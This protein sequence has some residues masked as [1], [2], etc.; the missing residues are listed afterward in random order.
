MMRCAP[1]ASNGPSHLGLCTLHRESSIQRLSRDWR[2]EGRPTQRQLAA[3]APEAVGREDGGGS[4]L[5]EQEREQNTWSTGTRGGEGLQ[6]LRRGLLRVRPRAPRTHTH[7]HAHTRACERHE[8]KCEAGGNCPLSMKGVACLALINDVSKHIFP[9]RTVLCSAHRPP[10]PPP[11][12]PPCRHGW[13][14]ASLWRGLGDSFPLRPPPAPRD[15][16]P[17]ARLSAQYATT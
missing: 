12:P 6:G 7:T 9:R 8:C 4:S 11:C 17:R 13:C 14:R 5:L 16:R 15:R 2:W 10:R 1:R 3:E